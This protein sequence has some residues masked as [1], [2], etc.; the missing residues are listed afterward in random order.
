MTGFGKP[1]SP[2]SVFDGYSAEIASGTT[3]DN[4]FYAVQTYAQPIG[5]IQLDVAVDGIRANSPVNVTVASDSVRTPKF[6][7]I[8]ESGQ[9]TTKVPSISVSGEPGSRVRLFSKD[10]DGNITDIGG[11]RLDSSGNGTVVSEAEFSLG[12]N[13]IF[14][15]DEVYGLSSSIKYV[16]FVD[17]W[18][19][20]YDSVTKRPIAGA[21]VTLLDSS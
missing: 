16:V 9:L 12:E 19:Y 3:D 20:V 18:G 14:A 15:I 21:K 4:G 1:N 17:P 2:V 11:V 5:P 8:P 13:V 7:N 10:A 6:T